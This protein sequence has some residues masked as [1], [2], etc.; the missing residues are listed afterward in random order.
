MKLTLKPDWDISSQPPSKEAIQKMG[1]FAGRKKELSVLYNELLRR[2]QGAILIN[3]YR[4]VGKTSFVYKTLQDVFDYYHNKK[5][6]A[7][8]IN[9]SSLDE[10]K[11]EGNILVNLIRRLYTASLDEQL[12]NDLRQEIEALY[13]KAVSSE[14]KY[15][16]ASEKIQQVARETESTQSLMI[17]SDKIEITRIIWFISFFIATILQLYPIP[18]KVDW[19]NKIL[20]LLFAFPV[21]F[22]ASFV[23]QYRVKVNR[24]E[25]N[26]NSAKKL[27]TI[28]NSISNLEFDLDKLHQHLSKEGVKTIYVVDELDKLEVK[29]VTEILKYFKNLFTL[30]RAI[31]IFV[32]SE[33]LTEIGKAKDENKWRPIEYTYFTSRYF[34]SRP[35]AEELLEFIDDIVNN[36]DELNNDQEYDLIKRSFIVDAKCDYFDLIQTIKGNITGFSGLYPMIEKKA[37]NI[38]TRQAKM[39][40]IISLLYNQKYFA[41]HPSRWLENEKVL[42]TFY[43]VGEYLVSLSPGTS[44]MDDETGGNLESVA[45]NDLRRYLHTLGV[46]DFVV[47]EKIFGRNEEGGRRYP[48][49]TPREYRLTNFMPELIPENLSFTSEL[50][51]ELISTIEQFYQIVTNFWNIDAVLQGTPFVSTAKLKEDPFTY[52]YKINHWGSE[53]KYAASE[54]DKAYKKV[55]DRSVVLKRE[56]IQIHIKTINLAIE[57]LCTDSH[58]ILANLFRDALPKRKYTVSSLSEYGNNFSLDFS[59]FTE[60]ILELNIPN[61]IL[62]GDVPSEIIRGNPEH[63][64]KSF[65]IFCNRL[66]YAFDRNFYGSTL[67]R[68]VIVN[69]DEDSHYDSSKG[70]AWYN[71]KTAYSRDEITQLSNIIRPINHSL[72]VPS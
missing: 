19:I 9:S 12:P 27:Y 57:K 13:K 56:E 16:E 55:V 61:V 46:L 6:I 40:Q 63:M 29:Q 26:E 4:G 11:S 34:M 43:N 60:H 66:S 71:P 50:D 28:D 1:H 72:D 2:E 32:G 59:K 42:R 62:V 20:P 17:G 67:G 58:I 41:Y 3:G 35:T 24:T 21:P 14:F 33:E 10:K 52:V 51:E 65:M 30:S 44:V 49:K 70:V 15:V 39:Q 47:D 69:Q 45:R 8:L 18:G 31:F 25:Q 38:A 22:I 64:K 48:G 54:I 5:I 7:V 53:A 36:V 23:W 37:D 68:I